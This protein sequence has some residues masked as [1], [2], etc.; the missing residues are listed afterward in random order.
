[1]RA[2]LIEAGR[3]AT[4]DAGVNPLLNPITA[5][6]EPAEASED[7]NGSRMPGALEA[8]EGMAPEIT[9][10]DSNAIADSSELSP[11][12]QAISGV[13]TDD[14]R[15]QRVEDEADQRGALA[16]GRTEPPAA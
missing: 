14:W 8:T 13:N 2:A 12:E 7:G 11:E 4:A 16:E 15:K 5:P 1:D 3:T 6:V 9:T 10:H